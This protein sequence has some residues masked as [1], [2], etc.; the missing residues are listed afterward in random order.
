MPLPSGLKTH[1]M[2][3]HII[4]IFALLIFANTNAQHHKVIGKWKT[5]DDVT[6]KAIS[7]IEIF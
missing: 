2:K 7:I 4:Y 1:I 5:I 3:T 6:G